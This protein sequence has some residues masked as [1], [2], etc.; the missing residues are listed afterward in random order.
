M[1]KNILPLKFNIKYL[2][3]NIDNDIVNT[4]YPIMHI[5]ADSFP[6]NIKLI[7]LNRIKNIILNKLEKNF[8]YESLVPQTIK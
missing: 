5:G 4:I 8:T 3:D 6:D 2:K 7:H 1:Q